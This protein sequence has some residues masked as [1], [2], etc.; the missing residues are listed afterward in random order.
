MRKKL[1]AAALIFIII[2]S[3]FA[4]YNRSEKTKLNNMLAQE[5]DR[6]EKLQAEYDNENYHKYKF[7]GFDAG[8]IEEDKEYINKVFSDI[9]TF[10]NGDEFI[11]AKNAAKDIYNLDESFVDI[12]YDESGLYDI[13]GNIRQDINLKYD[14]DSTD[15]YLVGD[16]DG[17]RYYHYICDIY[18]YSGNYVRQGMAGLHIYADILLND[19]QKGSFTLYNPIVR[20]K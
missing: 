13:D 16:M 4:V 15:I 14:A 11:A 8:R 18:T 10:S 12:Y 1:A 9:L 19:E 20:N 17:G 7:E 3:L 2:G 5:E 6:L